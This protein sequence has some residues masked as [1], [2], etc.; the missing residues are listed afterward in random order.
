MRLLLL[1]DGEQYPGG[2]APRAGVP[3]LEPR[4]TEPETVGLRIPPYPMGAECGVVEDTQPTRGPKIA[5]PQLRPQPGQARVHATQLDVVSPASDCARSSR[6]NETCRPSSSSDSKSGGETRRPL[7]ATR[8]G[9]NATR[10][11]R[12]KPS[13]SASRNAD[14][15]AAVSHSASSASAR[16]DAASTFTLSAVRTLV[17]ESV[18][19]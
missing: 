15:I 19:I 16:C 4:L 6:S 10:G 9:P 17:A 1:T 7:M 13:M 2:L 11:F 3:G 8:T 5:R 14:S 18:S 12:P